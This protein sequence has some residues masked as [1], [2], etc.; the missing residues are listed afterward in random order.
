MQRLTSAGRPL[1][2]E[3]E[4]GL[5]SRGLIV[6]LSPESPEAISAAAL[7]A[8]QKEWAV[9]DGKAVDECIRGPL[10]IFLR[11][12]RGQ[13][14][15]EKYFVLDGTPPAMHF[16]DNEAA[17]ERHK[18]A[19]RKKDRLVLSAGCTVST[20]EDPFEERFLIHVSIAG[21]AKVWKLGAPDDEERT[22]WLLP[23]RGVADGALAAA[24]ARRLRSSTE[25]QAKAE[26]EAM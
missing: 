13:I 10:Q 22:R 15:R 26:A 20:P 4:R 12:R 24:D 19:A 17:Y 1:T 14:W 3:F 23:L 2:L 7:A 8:S 11:E 5:N 21:G 9:R 16:Y 6:P 25:V 18:G